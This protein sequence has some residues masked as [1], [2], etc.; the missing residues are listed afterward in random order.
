MKNF[1]STLAVTLAATLS[2]VLLTVS[3]ASFAGNKNKHNTNNRIG[4]HYDYAKVI[5]VKSIYRQVR[6]STPIKECW[7]VPVVHSTGGYSHPKSASGMAVG[8]ILGGVIGHQVGKGR[9]N[10]LATALGAIIGASIGHDAVNGHVQSSQGHRYTQYEEQCEVQ[11]QVS[12]D[13]VVD[14]YDVTYR[15]QGERYH[16]EMPYHPGKRIKLRISIA[17][18]I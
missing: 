16:I 15:Y 11:H 13:E 6:V 3:S 12:Y 5:N 2:V 18:V 7:N 1:Q 8:G 14:G 9:G 17:P 10:K 4:H